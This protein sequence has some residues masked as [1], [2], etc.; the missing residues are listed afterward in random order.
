MERIE[1]GERSIQALDHAGGCPL[2]R[3]ALEQLKLAAP[4]E[5]DQVCAETDELGT[6]PVMG[7]VADLVVALADR[8]LLLAPDVRGTGVA[9]EIG[10]LLPLSVPKDGVAIE[11]KRTK[12]MFLIVAARCPV[13]GELVCQDRSTYQNNY[14]YPLRLLPSPNEDGPGV[15]QRE[16]PRAAIRPSPW[17]HAG[18]L[19]RVT[20]SRDAP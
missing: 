18:G 11:R 2:V 6:G 14:E 7:Y 4:V 9:G 8:F 1:G 13:C 5:F 3:K 17:R 19:R 16:E 15:A 12:G 20:E 10:R